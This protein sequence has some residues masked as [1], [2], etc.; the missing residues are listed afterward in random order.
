MMRTMMRSS[1]TFLPTNPSTIS[2]RLVTQRCLKAE[3]LR[4]TITWYDLVS[5]CAFTLS[6]D[7]LGL[8][9]WWARLPFV[10]AN[11]WLR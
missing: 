4:Q 6:G 8:G 3:K 7:T 2:R 10:R 5:P 1:W 11:P 9:K